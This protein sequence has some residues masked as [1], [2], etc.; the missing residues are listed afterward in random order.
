MALCIRAARPIGTAGRA[1]ACVLL[2]WL[3]AWPAEGRPA[4]ASQP[5]A[6][7]PADGTMKVYP[8]RFYIIHTDLGDQ[9]AREAE[10][11]M[12]AMA[13]EY[14][15]R[16]RGL[17]GRIP[18]RL[19]FHI[20]RRQG[21]YLDQGGLRGSAG[22]YDGTKLMALA[23]E[24]LNEG[25]W[26]EIQHEGFHQFAH[27][28]ISGSLPVWVNEGLAEYF[29]YA[30]WTG[31]AFITGL[32]R[33][34]LLGQVQDAIRRRKVI[35]FAEIL[36]MDQKQWNAR[37][38]DPTEARQ[39]YDQ[40]WAMVHFLAHADEGRYAKPLARF[41]GDLSR[42]AEAKEAFQRRIGGN[43]AAFEAQY[44]QW[45]LGQSPAAGEDLYVRAV[46]QSLTSF[47]ARAVSQGQQFAS[48]EDF[49]RQAS[50]GGLKSHP[51]QWLPESLL[52]GALRSARRMDGWSI[53]A[54]GKV[55]QLV[56][57][58]PSGKA[59]RGSFS[60]AGGRAYNVAV[61]VTDAKE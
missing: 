51:Q 30:I 17:R 43:I 14:R 41:I 23:P 48:A 56:L 37:L 34:N 55:P 18:T 47:L 3:L 60:C 46:V 19:P 4:G 27:T 11:R 20:F 54:S 6:T 7:G 1:A 39:G 38:S 42:G 12:S 36:T 22:Q 13:E 31:D 28:V 35:P 58:L 24:G 9:A 8:G 32:V 44:E 53:D 16:T 40:A 45:W 29:A 5:P 21:D 2:N 15:R 50:A 57:K 33:P 10:V 26:H 52:T 61:S 25:V 49:L 59:F